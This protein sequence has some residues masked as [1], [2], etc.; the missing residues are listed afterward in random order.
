[1]LSYAFTHIPSPDSQTAEPESKLK[2]LEA[3]TRKFTLAPSVDLAAVAARCARQFTGA[4]LYALCSDT[5]MR[6]FR[7]DLQLL[8]EE[9]GDSEDEERPVVVAQEDFEAAIE[10]LQPSL[11]EAEILKYERIRDQ[12]KLASR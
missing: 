11:S 9:G 6:A 3:L 10:T 8:A 2:V 5:W 4:D 1:M 7:R 12:Y